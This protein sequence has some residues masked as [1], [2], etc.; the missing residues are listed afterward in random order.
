MAGEKIVVYMGRG[1]SKQ[2]ISGLS[3]RV[4]N[5]SQVVSGLAESPIVGHGYSMATPTGKMWREEDGVFRHYTAHNLLLHVISGT[6]II[7]GILF[8]WGFYRLFL[9]A[10]RSLRRGTDKRL[11]FLTI[12]VILFTFMIGIFGDS[13]VDAIDPTAVAIFVVLGLGIGNTQMSMEMRSP[14]LRTTFKSKSIALDGS[15]YG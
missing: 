14:P 12:L 5:W 2:Q 11:P 10:W 15:S 1:Q 9:P 8:I 13:I 3:G 7:G 6:G 4:S